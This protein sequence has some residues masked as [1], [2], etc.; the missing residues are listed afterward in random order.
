M[1]LF[2]FIKYA[3]DETV[4]TAVDIVTVPIRVVTETPEL[5]ED[6]MEGDVDEGT[7]DYLQKVIRPRLNEKD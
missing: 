5:L 6:V 7:R 2:D 1:G 4:K 3:V